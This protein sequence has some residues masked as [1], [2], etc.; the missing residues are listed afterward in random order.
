[1]NCFIFSHVSGVTILSPPADIYLYGTTYCFS[2][3]AIL[4]VNFINYYVYLP[5]FYNLQITSIYEYI[6]LRFDTKL[7]LL[8]SFLNTIAICLYMPLVIY[9]PALAFAQC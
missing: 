4:V 7:R 8:A 3:L 9:V 2:L 1:M 5:V 6:A